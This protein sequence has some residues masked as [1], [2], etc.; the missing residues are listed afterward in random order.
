MDFLIKFDRSL[1]WLGTS[2]KSLSFCVQG[3][4]LDFGFNAVPTRSHT[5][6]NSL[7]LQLIFHLVRD[8]IESY[9]REGESRRIR[10]QCVSIPI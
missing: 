2:E 8:E 6:K 9:L 3:L 7:R 5:D 4:T 10:A 1:V